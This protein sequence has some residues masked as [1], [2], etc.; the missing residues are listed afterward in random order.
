MRRIHTEH[1]E[2]KR[3][4]K[5]S[6]THGMD[7]PTLLHDLAEQLE[8][9]KIK[10]RIKKAREEAGLTQTE[11]GDLMVPPAHMRTVQDWE[12]ASTGTVPFRHVPR[13][14]EVTGRSTT[15]LLHGTDEPPPEFSNLLAEL[16]QTAE[17]LQEAATS[18]AESADRVGDAAARLRDGRSSDADGA[19]PQ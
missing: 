19:P 11:L 10:A 18:L 12:S 16:R 17:A 9:A 3:H 15:W 2:G 6:A 13:I 7:T 8:R 4:V 1:T 14:A 5:V